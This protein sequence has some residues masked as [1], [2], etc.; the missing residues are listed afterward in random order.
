MSSGS[1]G[2]NCRYIVLSVSVGTL[3][4]SLPFLVSVVVFSGCGCERRLELVW[5]RGDVECFTPVCFN[6]FGE[7]CWLV[8]SVCATVIVNSNFR[9]AIGSRVV[10]VGGCS[11]GRLILD[12]RSW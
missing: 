3:H 6:I 7:F 4:I 1:G 2:V 5:N 12:V 9:P 11:Y 10:V 8:R